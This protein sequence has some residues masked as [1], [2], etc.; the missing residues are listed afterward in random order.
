MLLWRH[1]ESRWL[2]LPAVAAMFTL[3]WQS[4]GMHDRLEALL[5]RKGTEAAPNDGVCEHTRPLVE[6]SICT[7]SAQRSFMPCE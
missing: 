7:G 3:L 1:L 5:P 4:A 6:H 2:E